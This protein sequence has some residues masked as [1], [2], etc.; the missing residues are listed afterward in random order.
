MGVVCV[1]VC[2]SRQEQ[3]Y[4]MKRA[5]FGGS[6]GKLGCRHGVCTDGRLDP[7]RVHV[8]LRRES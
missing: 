8:D 5:S 1:C 7:G 2:L 4:G 3:L 6:V